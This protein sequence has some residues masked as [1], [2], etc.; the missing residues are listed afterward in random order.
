M[1]GVFKADRFSFG[2]KSQ[3]IFTPSGL[4]VSKLRNKVQHRSWLR[5]RRKRIHFGDAGVKGRDT[6]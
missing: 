2:N 1:V 3:F 4:P 6:L 5:L